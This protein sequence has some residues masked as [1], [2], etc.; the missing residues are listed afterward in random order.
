MSLMKFHPCNVLKE[1]QVDYGRVYEKLD[2]AQDVY[3]KTDSM[4]A[5]MNVAGRTKE[6][7]AVTTEIERFRHLC[8]QAKQRT[9]SVR[10]G[11]KQRRRQH[12]RRRSRTRKH[13]KRTRRY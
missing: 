7:L 10:G 12:G 4:P 1:K 8:D 6:L 11:T 5:L 9:V 13:T 3:R 2:I